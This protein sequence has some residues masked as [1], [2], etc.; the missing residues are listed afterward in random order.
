LAP[1][2]TQ[3]TSGS[4]PRHSPG[5]RPASHHARKASRSAPGPASH[6][7]HHHL[8][9]LEL[10][11]RL[12]GAGQHASTSGADTPQGLQGLGR[13]A[14]G[15]AGSRPARGKPV[16]RLIGAKDL[17]CLSGLAGTAGNGS[18][19]L[20]WRIVAFELGNIDA[21]NA[22]LYRIWGV[23]SLERKKRKTGK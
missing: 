15:G 4:H 14:G 23:W 10:I 1:R 18:A 8:V 13:D 2:S 9:H 19:S 22:V 5:S 6:L 16:A 17:G 11:E 7:R 20:G 3:R 21:L 12:R